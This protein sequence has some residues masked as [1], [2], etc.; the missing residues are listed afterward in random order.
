[1]SDLEKKKLE[2]CKINGFSV[3]KVNELHR[4][5]KSF[6]QM[7]IVMKP[8]W[9]HSAAAIIMLHLNPSLVGKDSFY[10]KVKPNEAYYVQIAK[11]ILNSD[12]DGVSFLTHIS[13]IPSKIIVDDHNKV[14][15]DT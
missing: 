10:N 7:D 14:I 1:M 5:N 2:C 8:Q 3:D 12:G 15:L 6:Y 13:Q 11:D 9:F 4:W